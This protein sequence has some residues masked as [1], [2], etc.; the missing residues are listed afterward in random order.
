MG[1]RVE[2]CLVY[3]VKALKWLHHGLDLEWNFRNYTEAVTEEDQIHPK[4]PLPIVF[5]TERI[6]SLV[7]YD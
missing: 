1:G 6:V 5:N 3:H 4:P 7:S 2:I